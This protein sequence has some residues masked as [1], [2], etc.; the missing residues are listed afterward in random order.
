M[1]V[2]PRDGDTSVFSE[3]SSNEG[4]IKKI[5]V[6][7][8]QVKQLAETIIEKNNILQAKS[9]LVAEKNRVI[10]ANEQLL[11]E[12]AEMLKTLKE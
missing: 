10:E 8:E 7:E 1:S 2:L 11:S 6:L 4:L 5:G 12:N 3:S 9:E